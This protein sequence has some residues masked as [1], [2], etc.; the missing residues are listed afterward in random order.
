MEGLSFKGLSRKATEKVIGGIAKK[1]M[2][3]GAVSYHPEL[4]LFRSQSVPLYFSASPLLLESR[5]P[6]PF[7]SVSTLTPTPVPSL[8]F[9]SSPTLNS[10]AL[11]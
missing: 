2:G 7:V 3:N 1:M 11:Q 8:P 4:P 5:S 9:A 10:P 6:P